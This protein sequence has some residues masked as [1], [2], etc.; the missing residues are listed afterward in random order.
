MKTKILILSAIILSAIILS[1][2]IFFITRDRNND[3]SSSMGEEF[4]ESEEVREE[5]LAYQQ[6][7][8]S[9]LVDIAESINVKIDALINKT[10][11]NLP[12]IP[13]EKNDELDMLYSKFDELRAEKIIIPE[14]PSDNTLLEYDKAIG[15]L[16]L[17][18]LEFD[19]HLLYQLSIDG[20]NGTG[21]SFERHLNYVIEYG[22]FERICGK[23]ID[24]IKKIGTNYSTQTQISEAKKHFKAGDKF[25]STHLQG[26]YYII[27][28]LKIID[29][30]HYEWYDGYSDST[31]EHIDSE[32]M[33]S[34]TWTIGYYYGGLG[35]VLYSEGEATRHWVISDDYNQ[36]TGDGGDIYI[37]Q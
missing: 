33:K 14:K 10:I 12:Q 17:D 27:S 22:H 26:T 19:E 21:N 18:L 9:E 13:V 30:T 11:S 4:Y 1:V 8:F 35:I 31:G 34:G 28:Y 25:K 2:S 32:P 36:L 20:K 5:A 29:D 7:Y 15:Q 23:Q 24:K 3:S 16:E 37:R 6:Q